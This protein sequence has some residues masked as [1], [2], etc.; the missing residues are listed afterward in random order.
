MNSSL[1]LLAVAAVLAGHLAFAACGFAADNKDQ[2][3]VTRTAALIDRHIGKT[4]KEN[5]IKPAPV[6]DDAEFARRAYLNIAGRIPRVSEVHEFLND[7]SPD[8]RRKLVAKL[9][10]DPGY[11]T[12][13]TT[14]WRT[15]LLP[16][17]QADF[18]SRYL[19]PG[20]E[21]WLRGK[22]QKGETYDAMVQELLTMPLETSNRNR[23]RNIYVRMAQSSPM[24]F[25]Q[26]KQAEP[27]NLASAV[28]RMFLGVRIG[29]AQ[30]HDHPFD[31]WKQ[32]QFWGFAAFFAGVQRQGNNVFGRVREVKDKR[33]IGI[34]NTE[35]VVQAT[36]LTGEKPQWRF[37]QGARDT[38]AKW[39][40]SKN[41]PYFAKAA[42][43]RIWG[44]L[45]GVGLVDPV[46]DFT[47]SN[48]ASHPELLEALAKEFTNQNFDVKFLIKAI[49]ASKTY[50]RTS[51]KTDQSQ[52]NPQLFARMAVQGMTPEQL[53]DSL[54]TAVGVFQPFQQ[55]NPFVIGRNDPRSEILQLFENTSE[56]P[57]ERTTTILQ[58][59]AMMNGKFVADATNVRN[60]RTLSAVLDA[61]FTTPAERIETLYIAALSR[62]P[63]PKEL[64]RLL[65]Y[66]QS[67]GPKQN[68]EQAYADVF[69]A[70][71]NSSEF[72]LNH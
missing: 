72:M 41:N 3:A 2:D 56:A 35:K 49:S 28:S 67:G 61:P 12:H 40:T 29:C 30:C 66:I 65:K 59:L 18:Q 71:L 54:A 25:Y 38:L 17:V 20:F 1:R 36:F 4:W 21:S 13:Y 45:F 70:L 33:E 22:L 27:E 47:S 63:K 37:R 64:E 68:T 14:F 60:S 69:W 34:P 62:K 8:K 9:L 42:V 57:T 46:D 48:P 15:V 23:N 55:Q 52:S 32:E 39:V 6:A 53:Y 43:N 16:E 26:S 58:A 5:G 7:K 50:Q 44:K 51:R 19:I 24:A 11:I 10:E 31:S